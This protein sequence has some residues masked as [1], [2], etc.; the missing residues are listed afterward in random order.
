MFNPPLV[1]SGGFTIASWNIRGLNNPLK[2]KEVRSL[3]VSQRLGLCGVFE[4]KV[5][6]TNLVAICT[7][8]F[9]YSWKWLDNSGNSDIA[10]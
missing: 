9:P 4:A 1:S 7:R 6:K 3:I 2:Q 8:C 10:S 5:R